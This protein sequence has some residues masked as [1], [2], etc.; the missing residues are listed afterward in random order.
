MLVVLTVLACSELR[1]QGADPLLDFQSTCMTTG[2][3]FGTVTN[4]RGWRTIVDLGSESEIVS[5]SFIG[6]D[7]D[8]EIRW[9]EE[10]GSYSTAQSSSQGLSVRSSKIDIKKESRLDDDFLYCARYN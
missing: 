8:A 1:A 9:V 4:S 5:F 10:D 6:S 7:L 3:H 2:G